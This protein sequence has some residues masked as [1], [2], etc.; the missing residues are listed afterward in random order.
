MVRSMIKTKEMSK[1]FW[2]KVYAVCGVHTESMPAM[3][4]SMIEPPKNS[5]AVTN[6]MLHISRYSRA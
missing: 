2:A 5:G 6:P 1:E 4:F 3:H